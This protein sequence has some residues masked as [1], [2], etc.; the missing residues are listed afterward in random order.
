MKLFNFSYGSLRL[1]I[2]AISVFFLFI[3]SHVKRFYTELVLA[4]KN[5]KLKRSSVTAL[6][7]TIPRGSFKLW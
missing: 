1:S 2:S 6:P 7:S 3:Y 4:E 5:V